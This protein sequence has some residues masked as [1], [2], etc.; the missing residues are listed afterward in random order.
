MATA[1]A[2]AIEVLPTPGGP[3]NNHAEEYGAA[4][5]LLNIRF[6]FSKPTNSVRFRGRYFSLSDVGKFKPAC[7]AGKF[8]KRDIILP[9]FLRNV[10]L[11]C[12]RPRCSAR[13]FPANQL[14]TEP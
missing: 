11:V 1:S 2:S 6:G 8:W 14:P 13:Q 9:R 10:R 4:A 12:L 3:T 7:A 5:N